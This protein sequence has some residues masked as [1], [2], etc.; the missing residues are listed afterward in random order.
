MIYL[1]SRLH[2]LFR[3]ENSANTVSPHL[4]KGAVV[5]PS[6]EVTGSE[7]CFLKT[8]LIA[9]EI[10]TMTLETFIKEHRK[11][12]KTLQFSAVINPIYVIFKC[13]LTQSKY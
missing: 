2:I 12:G 10:K 4:I 11:N 5:Q 1:L 13:A 8:T 6:P 9:T 7:S 3:I